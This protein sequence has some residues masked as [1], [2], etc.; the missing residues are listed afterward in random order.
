MSALRLSSRKWVRVLGLAVA[1]YGVAW[2]ITHFVGV[3]SVYHA[4]KARMPITS[5]FADTDVPHRVRGSADSPVYFCRAVAYGPFLVRAD[6]GWQTE[7]LS[8][9]GG[10]DLYFWF[11][12]YTARIWEL[13][14]WMS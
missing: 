8:G 14:H 6:F 12:G 5:E 7:S 13:D 1:G 10:S 3:R 11:F 9:D 4:A 2:F